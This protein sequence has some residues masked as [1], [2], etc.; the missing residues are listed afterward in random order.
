MSSMGRLS[1]SVPWEVES[2]RLGGCLLEVAD[3]G[4]D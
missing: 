3:G 2:A 4:E 1:W